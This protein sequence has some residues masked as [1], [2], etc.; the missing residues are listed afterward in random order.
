MID[1]ANLSAGSRQVQ[2]HGSP[3]QNFSARFARVGVPK[4]LPAAGKPRST[5]QYS[6]T[7][8][9][10]RR[11]GGQAMRRWIPGSSRDRL[12][13]DHITEYRPPAANSSS[14]DPTSAI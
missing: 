6:P 5:P 4:A 3:G 12:N 7:R 10:P 2:G 13:A 14:W 8:R 1:P 11:G 9:P